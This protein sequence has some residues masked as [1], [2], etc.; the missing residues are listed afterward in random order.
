M[1]LDNGYG[2]SEVVTTATNHGGFDMAIAFEIIALIFCA[3]SMFVM[4][5]R[6]IRDTWIPTLKG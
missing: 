3:I 1:M 4:L 6:W 5:P 2:L